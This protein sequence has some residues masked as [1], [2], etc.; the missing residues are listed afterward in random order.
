MKRHN[1]GEDETVTHSLQK[2]N[3]LII[4]ISRRVE[5]RC[6]RLRETVTT[7]FNPRCNSILR[8]LRFSFFDGRFSAG[9]HCSLPGHAHGGLTSL[10]TAT[11][12]SPW[13]TLTNCS[14]C[15]H[16]FIYNFIAPTHSFRFVI[17]VICFRLLTHVSC[18][19]V[20]PVGT[21]CSWNPLLTALSKVKTQ[22]FHFFFRIWCLD[23]KDYSQVKNLWD[24]RHFSCVM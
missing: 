19:L 10:L 23:M 12:D 7:F 3:S 14:I 9:G 21:S 17:N 11:P 16:S 6:R 2:Y 4:L 20:Y 13:L 1:Q 8:G 5:I 24:I 18:P 15:G 22:L